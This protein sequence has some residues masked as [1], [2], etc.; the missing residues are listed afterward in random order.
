MTSKEALILL[1][2]SHFGDEKAT[3]EVDKNYYEIEGK[4]FYDLDRL[5]KLE[6]ENQ[7]LKEQVNHLN[8]VIE[9]MQNPSK[10]DC[11]HMFDNCKELKPLPEKKEYKMTSKEALKLAILEYEKDLETDENNQWVKNV[12]KGLKKCQQDLEVLEIIKKHK[13]L[14][15]VLKNEKC[16]NMYHLSKEEIDLLR[17]IEK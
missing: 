15:Y 3:R 1:I 4:L 11:T 2:H 17:E 14:N 12:L 7:E 10:L 6:K 16:A 9:V 8:K 13:L 5:E